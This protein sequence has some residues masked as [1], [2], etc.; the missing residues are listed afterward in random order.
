[1]Q[2]YE[3]CLEMYGCCVENLSRHGH[4]QDIYQGK[5]QRNQKVHEKMV[6]C[7]KTTK[8]QEL[9]AIYFFVKSEVFSVILLETL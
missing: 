6:Y 2:R 8:S 5:A 9:Y 7:L 1:M 3:K 4:P